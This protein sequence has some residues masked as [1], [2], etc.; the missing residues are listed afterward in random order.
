MS[1]PCQLSRP[2]RRH[3]L[4]FGT[5]ATMKPTSLGRCSDRRLLVSARADIATHTG[6]SNHQEADDEYPHD[7]AGAVRG[8]SAGKCH[9][10][11]PDPDINARDDAGL[12]AFKYQ[13]PPKPASFSCSIMLT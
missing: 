5:T 2:I 6:D 11:A 13:T 12:P 8:A 3:L 1:D 7:R 4:T 10:E 9:P